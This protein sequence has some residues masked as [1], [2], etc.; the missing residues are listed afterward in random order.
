VKRDAVAMRL[1]IETHCA[2]LL[3]AAASDVELQGTCSQKEKVIRGQGRRRPY[4]AQLPTVVVEMII[5]S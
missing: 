2:N 5:A 4:K 1:L 3:V